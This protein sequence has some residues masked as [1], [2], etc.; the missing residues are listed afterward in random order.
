MV[1]ASSFGAID[2]GL[3]GC[4]QEPKSQPSD[5]PPNP[6]DVLVSLFPGDNKASAL[7]SA[8]R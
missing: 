5:S 6:A 3:N 1:A 7:P 2:D 4:P 8:A